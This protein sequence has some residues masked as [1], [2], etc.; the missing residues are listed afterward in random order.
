MIQTAKELGVAFVAFSPLGHGWLVDDFQ[1]KSP[2][3]FDLNDFRRTSKYHHL[4]VLK[5]IRSIGFVKTDFCKSQFRS[6]REKT[7]I[8]TRLSWTRSRH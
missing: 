5:Y 3:D 8:R 4:H 1:F 6:S 2:D 7:S